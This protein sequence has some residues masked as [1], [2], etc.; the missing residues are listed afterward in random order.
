MHP[1][2]QIRRIVTG[3]DDSGK[4]IVEMDGI[5]PHVR[6]RP[7]AGFVSSLLWVTDETPARMDLRRDRAERTI[8]V[9]PPPNGSI[10]R[11]VDFP[12]VDEQTDKIDQEA[13]LKSMGAGHHAHGGGPAR[14]PYMH[15]TKSVDYAI[16]L[17]GEI[18]MLLDDSEV[19]MKAGDILV[20]Q[21]TNHAWV[22]RSK[23]VCRI[24][25]VLIDGIDPLEQRQ[26]S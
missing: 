11:V 17:Q 15:R 18:D 9:P 20:Q 16:V 24:A 7:G 2:H 23:E 19:H 5:C 25:F 10:L 13:L 3:H 14:H 26:K 8:G 4:A 21:G 22:N 6:V 1:T 12:P